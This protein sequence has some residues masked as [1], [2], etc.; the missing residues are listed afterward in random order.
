MTE[1]D[2]K[3]VCETLSKLNEDHLAK[4]LND[5]EN[6]NRFLLDEHEKLKNEKEHLNREKMNAIDDKERYSRSIVEIK[7]TIGKIQKAIEESVKDE[8]NKRKKI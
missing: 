3:K 4:F 1:A 6:K 8:E 7:D 5:L 2:A